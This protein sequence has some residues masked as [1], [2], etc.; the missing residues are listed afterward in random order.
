MF[1]LDF[2]SEFDPVYAGKKNAR[3]GVNL[4]KKVVQGQRRT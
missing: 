4:E 1:S 2:K 3:E